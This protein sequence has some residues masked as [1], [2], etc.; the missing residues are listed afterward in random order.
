[1]GEREQPKN[2]PEE[3]EKQKKQIA[4]NETSL[5]RLVADNQALSKK[6]NEQVSE[7]E[8]L[9]AELGRADEQIAQLGG[10]KIAAIEAAD[11]ARQLADVK[12][13]QINAQSKVYNKTRDQL[14]AAGVE[15]SGEKA[16]NER[17][18]AEVVERTK[19][20][21]YLQTETGRL[22]TELTA[23]ETLAG[24]QQARAD[25]AE[26]HAVDNYKR[27]AKAEKGR[28]LENRKK[29][30]GVLGFVAASLLCVYLIQNPVKSQA[31]PIKEKPVV[32]QQAV[33]ER[34][35]YIDNLFIA[36]YGS[37]VYRMSLKK[38]DEIFARME[39]DGKGSTPEE[40]RDYFRKQEKHI[41]DE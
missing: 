13:A 12:E 34:H 3:A 7:L 38:A 19:E 14:D 39:K 8:R 40:R 10:E 24:T 22:G 5:D 1:M 29:R 17:L 30:A 6:I 33:D 36:R 26:K 25:T 41:K 9:N 20:V 15:L 11:S 31:P 4:S 35:E 27:A 37:E 32:V 21:G 28:K 18:E 2:Q 16:K 23:A